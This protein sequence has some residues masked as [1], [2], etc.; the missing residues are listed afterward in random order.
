M[1]DKASALSSASKSHCPTLHPNKVTLPSAK[2]LTTLA[3]YFGVELQFTVV[4]CG[5]QNVLNFAEYF[6]IYNGTFPTI[7]DGNS[8]VYSFFI[9][10]S[11]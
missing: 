1:D 7:N 4:H 11:L 2:F 5:S 10:I 3:F 6:D 9:S 8:K